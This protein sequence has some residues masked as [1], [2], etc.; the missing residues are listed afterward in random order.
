M[1]SENTRALAA[2]RPETP[3]HYRWNARIFAL[4]SALFFFAL[5][6]VSGNTVLPPLIDQLSG[7]KIVVGIASGLFSA[8]WLLP[9]VFTASASARHQRK[10]PLMIR[11]AW[12]GRVIYLLTALGIWWL[13]ADHPT[14]TLLVV[15]ISV[16]IFF[17]L[18]AVVAVPWFDLLAK[19][20]PPQ[21]RGRL[22]GLSQALG[23]LGGVAVGLAVRYVLSDASPWVFPTNY[24]ILFAGAGLFFLIDAA[25][26]S[27]IREPESA[28][29]TSAMPPTREILRQMPTLLASDY[30][31]RRLI[32]VRLASG[33]I[34][35]ASAFYVLHAT[36]QIGLG[37]ESTGLFVSGQVVGGLVAGLLMGL[38]QDRYGPLKHIRVVTALAAVPPLLALGIEPLA[39][40]LGESVVYAYVLVFFFLG[41]YAGSAGWPY[42]NWI[43]EYAG[44]ARRPLYIGMINT[45]SGLVTLAPTLGG[46]VVDSI[47]YRAVFVLSLCFVVGTLVLSRKLPSP[48]H[49]A[50]AAET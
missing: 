22:L 25:S 33:F 46:W 19:C 10:K 21:R 30:A 17:L 11:A 20:I 47:S 4:E 27:L 26:L 12:P 6:F 41:I 45:L 29:D 35:M 2:A 42:F 37:A 1:S 49:G 40:R 32:I 39:P 7:S 34:G 24:A 36:R 28:L 44:E 3:S 15:V 43:L 5:S 50:T 8:A 48:R 13:G 9:Q 23:S 18:D 16:V 14:V 31:F 38:V